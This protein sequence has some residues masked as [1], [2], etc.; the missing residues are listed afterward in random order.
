MNHASLYKP[1]VIPVIVTDHI[2]DDETA[3]ASYF[4]VGKVAT[5]RQNYPR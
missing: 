2:H 1:L 3:S 4:L 5:T